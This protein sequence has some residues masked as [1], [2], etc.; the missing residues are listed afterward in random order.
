MTL[1]TKRHIFY[2]TY[3]KLC[4]SFCS[5]LQSETDEM[6]FDLCDLDLWPLTLISCVDI[7]FV[8]GNNS[9]KCHDDTMTRTKW[10]GVADRQMD[11]RTDGQK[12]V[13]L[14]LLGG[15]WKYPY[16]ITFLWLSLIFKHSFE[17]STSF[18]MA[19]DISRKNAVIQVYLTPA[20]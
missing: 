11:E 10:K 20:I 4:A 12:E 9:W 3:F 6:G 17:R 13:F 1:K 16:C 8:N 5:Q 14:E 7:T 2:A 18:K 19:D 15:S